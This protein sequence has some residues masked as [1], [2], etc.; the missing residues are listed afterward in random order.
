MSCSSRILETEILDMKKIIGCILKCLLCWAAV[1][2]VCFGLLCA[3]AAVPDGR[4]EKNLI[5]SADKMAARPPHEHL[6][7]SFY[8]SV[9]D[10]YADAVLLGVAAN[11]S[12][13]DLPRSALDT[14]YYDD[15]FGPAVGIKATVDGKPANIDYTRY[16]HGSLVFVRPLLAVADIS[17]IR[18]VGSVVIA[19]LFAADA[20]Y[21]LYKKQKAACVIF[22]VSAVLVSFWYVFTTLEYMSVFIIMLAALP[23]FVKYADNSRALTLISVGTGT[24]TAFADFLTAETLT[25]LVPL[26]MAFFVRAGRGEKPDK[27]DSL[28]TALSC[29]AGWGVA[30]LATFAAKWV[31]ASAALGRDVSSDAV[32]AAELR[33]NG[34][35]EEFSSPIEMMFSALGANLSML[36]PTDQKVSA[37]W[38]LIW[39]AAFT[40][41]CVM[42]SLSGTRR[43]NLPKAVMIVIALIPIIRF[44]LLMNHSYLHNFFT[45]RALM[46]SIMAVLGLVWYRVGTAKKK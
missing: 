38:I 20:V 35:E 19:L 4:L 13:D 42:I 16:W 32:A 23:L 46:P 11:M 33:V 21:L 34:M 37:V 28:V 30:Y 29:M 14:R 12:S 43:H 7:K 8:S 17:G 24:L 36:A 44:C 1:L 41:V 9:C 25:I 2:A 27:K 26:V 22:L 45:Y 3:A 39:L 31:L 6:Q 18:L 15:G 10:N 40:A 5:S